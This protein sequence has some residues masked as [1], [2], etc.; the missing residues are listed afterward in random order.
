MESILLFLIICA[1]IIIFKIISKVRFT[2]KRLKTD[3][4]INKKLKEENFN[5]T[6]TLVITDCRTIALTKDEAK[7]KIFIDADNKKFFLTDYKKD[8][9]FVLNFGDVIDCEIYETS[10]I[11]SEGNRRRMKEFCNNLKLIIKIDN[12]DYPQ[13]EYDIVFG[14]RRVDKSSVQY[15]N[16]RDGLQEIKSFFDV[17]K[18][19]KTAKR[20]K[21]IYCIY[22]GAKNHDD[23]LKCESC[24]GNLK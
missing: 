11:A 5:A 14:R 23:S 6:K 12:I 8:K 13:I 21:F 1:V 22:C 4:K 18:S 15:Q 19:E 7:Q 17:I 9:F 10:A 3:E 20:K 16:L 24:G 2:K